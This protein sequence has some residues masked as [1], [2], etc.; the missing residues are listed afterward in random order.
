[1]TSNGLP[2]GGATPSRG[3]NHRIAD[4]VLDGIILQTFEPARLV[5]LPREVKERL[6]ATIRGPN[7]PSSP[8]TGSA[9]SE[10]SLSGASSAVD[11]AALRRSAIEFVQERLASTGPGASSS[12]VERLRDA[13]QLIALRSSGT[14]PEGVKSAAY[15]L[16]RVFRKLGSEL[17]VDNDNKAPAIL[18]TGRVTG[19]LL[20]PLVNRSKAE[21]DDAAFLLSAYTDTA[22][23]LVELC[24]TLERGSS[25]RYLAFFALR[26]LG[27]WSP[28]GWDFKSVVGDLCLD[29]L[30]TR[31]GA[32]SDWQIWPLALSIVCDGAS[33]LSN[34]TEPERRSVVAALLPHLLSAGNKGYRDDL[35][36]RIPPRHD[37]WVE[38]RY[39]AALSLRAFI[40]GGGLRGL[41]P[42]DLQDLVAVVNLESFSPNGP[43]QAAARS[44]REALE[45]ERSRSAK[46]I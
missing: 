37:C 17:E 24:R 35:D 6:L 7:G 45:I 33:A 5:T 34:R 16:G 41:M 46:S 25:E 18:S 10:G 32:E 22:R 9:V 26:I 20:G 14:L 31:E 15:N 3:G 39:L 42:E 4:E 8:E 13:G 12:E 29:E 23:S 40:Q 28:K 19:A 36:K 44:V 30:R 1:M 27:T 21:A 2:I 43:V 11:P 38:D